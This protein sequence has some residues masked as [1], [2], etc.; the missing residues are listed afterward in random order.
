M[1][2]FDTCIIVEDAARVCVCMQVYMGTYIFPGLQRLNHYTIITCLK[3]LTVTND[4][5]AGIRWNLTEKTVGKSSEWFFFRIYFNSFIV[6]QVYSSLFRFFLFC[7]LFQRRLQGGPDTRPI[8][9]SYI[10]IVRCIITG[11][12]VNA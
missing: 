7:S 11:L 6:S 10:Y 5:G 12:V 4:N 9:R 1:Y 2:I 3:T 8:I